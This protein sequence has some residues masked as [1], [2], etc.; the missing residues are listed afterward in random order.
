M[1]H[2]PVRFNDEQ[3]RAIV[4]AF[5]EIVETLHLKIY[6]CAV[7]QDHT[8]F[9]PHRHREDI[10]TIIGFLKRAATRRLNKLGLHPFQDSGATP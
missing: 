2:K 9:V 3:R 6:A 1:L 10:E 5:G 8:H 7:L 4:G